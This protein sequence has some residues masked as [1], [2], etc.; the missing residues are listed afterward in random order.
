MVGEG[1]GW[2]VRGEIRASGDWI[3]SGR[4]SSR[5]SWSWVASSSSASSSSGG[6]SSSSIGSPF[7][8]LTAF[9][10]IG[11]SEGFV[12][13]SSELLLYFGAGLSDHGR[14]FILC[15]EFS[16]PRV[17]WWWEL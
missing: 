8:W 3:S 1:R 6:T 13:G 11:A 17:G 4:W 10:F 15:R 16:D 7:W 12:K 2:E 5:G 9:S 14:R